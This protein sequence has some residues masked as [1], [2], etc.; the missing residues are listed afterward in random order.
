MSIKGMKYKKHN[1]P[2][3]DVMIERV[4]VEVYKMEHKNI[5][6]KFKEVFQLSCYKEII[7]PLIVLDKDIHSLQELSI[8]YQ[9]SKQEVRTILFRAFPNAKTRVEI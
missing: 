8:K 2:L 5:T 3:R 1:H 6:D 4:C 9:I 7:K